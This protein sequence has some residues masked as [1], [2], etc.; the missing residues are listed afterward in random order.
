L[1]FDDPGVD[2]SSEYSNLYYM[3]ATFDIP[4]DLYRRVKA[5][6]A[7]EGRP[8]RSVA[9]QLF[10][11]WLDGPPPVAQ[12]PPSE[13]SQEE[14]NAAPWLAISRRYIKP[15]MSH[16]MDEIRAAIAAGSAAE[17]AEKLA[18]TDS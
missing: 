12:P 5:R 11:N 15:G 14:L 2:Y 8:L 13:L 4:D 7:M 17:T 9:V 1:Y 6:S 16:D 18:D 3:K 10:Q